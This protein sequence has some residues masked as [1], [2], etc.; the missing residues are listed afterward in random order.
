[1]IIFLISYFLYLVLNIGSNRT[2]EFDNVYAIAIV[3]LIVL[4]TILASTRQ[5]SNIIIILISTTI[6]AI[7][8]S[9]MTPYRIFNIV[10]LTMAFICLIY[11]IMSVKAFIVLRDQIFLKWLVSA[12]SFIAFLFLMF[13]NSRLS[14]SDRAP[15]SNILYIVGYVLYIMASFAMI[16]G[17]PNSNYPD[18]EKEHRQIFVRLV[19]SVWLFIFVLSTLKL[20]IPIEQYR[21]IIFPGSSTTKWHMVDYSLE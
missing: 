11:L 6:V 15:V 20:F 13:F 7:L 5:I 12:A 21:E 17:L 8:F 1:M 14:N 3:G 18:W 19:L 10:D 9:L 16:F 2:D 4:F